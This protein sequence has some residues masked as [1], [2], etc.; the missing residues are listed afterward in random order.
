MAIPNIS[1][2]YQVTNAA[3]ELTGILHG[4]SLNQITDLPDVW[5]RA[6]R[7]VLQDVD[8]AETKQDVQFGQVWD[9]VFD[10][11]VPVDVKG[12][13]IIDL[14]P[15]ANRLSTD[16]F[17]QTYNK[18][19]DLWKNY[20]LVPDFTPR[21][22]G[23]N[24]TIR[25]NAADL[26]TGIQINAADG[27]NTNGTWSTSGNASNIQTD[28]QYYTTGASGSVSFQL[29]GTGTPG[30][31]GTVTNS[32]MG[33]VNLSTQYNNGT[34]FFQ[35]YLPNASAITSV[36]FQLGSDAG[37]YYQFPA[38][39]T[40]YQGN[41]FVNGWNTIGCSWTLATIVGAPN[42]TAINYITTT[43]TYNG[44]LQTQVRINQYWSRL[45]VIFNINYYSKFLFMDSVTYAF[46]EFTTSNNDYI[47][48]DTDGRNLF[49]Y[50]AALE[51]I[52]Q[53]Q[54]LSAQFFDDPNIEAKYND[55]LSEYQAKYKSEITKPRLP[56][57]RLPAQGY[58]RFLGRGG[59]GYP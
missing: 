53:Q 1:T 29:N 11:A 57:Y 49:L 28:N 42:N 37:D 36:S 8:P 44:T 58:R 15:Q 2:T 41:N 21:Y 16:N 26:H 46:K 17:A 50:A 9:G 24:R 10:Y 55:A 5:N 27:V 14:Y 47:N 18:N 22:S 43:F 23:G 48:L 7:R 45:G 25:I 56:Y 32:T 51:A 31:T 59:Y 4:T 34:E 38:Q 3:N 20:S 39:T 40:D 52:Q 35:V 33:S 12:N 54:G 6:A 13:K 19:F 30:S